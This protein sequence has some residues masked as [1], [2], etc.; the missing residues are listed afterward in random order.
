MRTVQMTSVEATC[1]ISVHSQSCNYSYA[2][3]T[4]G[5]LSGTSHLGVEKFSELFLPST[6]SALQ[7]LLLPSMTFDL[8]FL[9]FSGSLRTP[10]LPYIFLVSC[11]L[12]RLL[13]I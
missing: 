2:Y 9:L 8:N 11:Y 12:G 5:L 1:L 10:N 4:V 3:D 7:R 13:C 6:T